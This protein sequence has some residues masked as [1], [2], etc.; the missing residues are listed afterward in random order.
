[1]KM[2]S[3]LAVRLIIVS[4]ILGLILRLFFALTLPVT[5]DGGIFL[6]WANLINNGAVPYRDFFIRDPVYIYLVALSVRAFGSNYLAIS[7]VSIVPSVLTVPV[8]YKIAKEVFDY[9]TGLASALSFG[10]APTI[11]WYSTGFD[12]RSV[13]L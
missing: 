1:M 5:W 4:M 6:Y 3:S 11:L 8:L 2:L 9:F 10:F 7:L 12:M 13:M